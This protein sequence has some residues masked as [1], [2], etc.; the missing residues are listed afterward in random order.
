LQ[1]ARIAAGLLGGVYLAGCSAHQKPMPPPQPSQATRAGA[2][3][4]TFVATAYSLHGKTAS[5]SVTRPGVVAADPRVLPLGSQ[6]RV[7]GAGAYSGTYT[8]A[9]TGSAIGGRRIDLYIP[10][11]AAARRFG[12]R[13]VHVELVRHPGQKTHRSGPHRSTHRRRRAAP[14]KG[15]SSV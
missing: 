10:N 8:V 13:T 1:L 14:G 2:P 11:H 5:G 6:I 15:A 9:D 3:R 12:R 4:G 7:R